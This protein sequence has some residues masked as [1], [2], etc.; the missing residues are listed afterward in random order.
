MA[1]SPAKSIKIINCED[2]GLAVRNGVATCQNCGSR[3]FD[4]HEYILAS[5]VNKER[6]LLVV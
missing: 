5:L 1:K 6:E 4:T 3:S 2:C